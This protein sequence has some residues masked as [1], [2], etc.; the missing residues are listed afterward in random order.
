MKSPEVSTSTDAKP[1]KNIGRKL[2]K[3]EDKETQHVAPPQYYDPYKSGV[4]T[5]VNND[6]DALSSTICFDD[7]L[8][9]SES[10]KYYGEKQLI[11]DESITTSDNISGL[12]IENNAMDEATKNIYEQELEMKKCYPTNYSF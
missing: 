2:Y 4:K 12:Y 3:P 1:C 10:A 11:I 6:A 5:E 9:Y 8:S 7:S